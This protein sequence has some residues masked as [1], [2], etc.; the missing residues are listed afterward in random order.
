M[1]SLIQIVSLVVVLATQIVYAMGVDFP[2]PN[3]GPAVAS[4]ND[5]V[6]TLENNVITATWDA[7][8]AGLRPASI[9]NK[10]TGQRFDQ[11]GSEL[12]RVSTK[13]TVPSDGIYGVAIRLGPDRITVF[14]SQDDRSP[15]EIASFPRT[16]FPGDPATIRVG[17]MNLKAQA[18]D[19]GGD[20]GA[21]GEG[22]IFSIRPAP[23]A[24]AADHFEFKTLA[25]KTATSSFPFPA[26]TKRVS[27]RIDKGT[28]TGL[29]WAPALALV[30]EEGT[31]F[32]LVGVR[33]NRGVFNVTTATGERGASPK[34]GEFPV[35]D[36]PA[37]AFK[38]LAPATISP[39]LLALNT[40]RIAESIPGKAI[41]AAFISPEGLRATW[42]AELRDGSNYIRQTVDFTAPEK[43]VSL[44]GVELIDTQL[45]SAQPIG[46]VPGCPVAGSGLFL[47]VEIPGSRTVVTD[48]HARIGFA[49]KLDVSPQ[50][51]YR[52]GAVTGIAP[53]GQLR[54]AFLYYIERERARASQPFLH[55]NC[56]YDLGYGLTED[57]I[58]DVVQQFDAELV[59]KRGVPVQSYL[60]DDG[61]DDPSKGL[62]LEH[63]KRFPTGFGGL[64]EKLDRYGAHLGIW[65][66][67][68]GGYGGDKERTALGRKMGL[69]PEDSIFDLS[70]PKYRQWFEDR[71]LQLMRECGVNAFKWDRAGNGVTPHFM[72]LLHVAQK[73]RLQN[74]DVFINVTAGTW[75]SPFWLNHV[76]STWRNNS[77]DVGW[78]GKG[79]DREK[80][81]TFRDGYCRKLFAIASPLYPLN[82]VMH[83]GL[84]HGRAFQGDKVGKSG[85]HLTNEA[86]SYFATGASL[87]ELYITPSMMT[88]EAWDAVAESAKWAHARADVLADSHWVGGD[89]LTLQ[90]YGYASWNARQGTLMLRNPDDQK[91]TMTIDATT[92]FELPATAPKNYTLTSPYADQRV[93]SITLSA[94]TPYEIN[95]E[96]F[97]VLVF[98]AIPDQH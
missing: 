60:A 51:S 28:D 17:K 40:R 64:K 96:P 68:L 41:E 86:R 2:G 87:Q 19:H 82:S 58:V 32:I 52:F 92:V 66:S 83:H 35:G 91:K 9:T 71:C 38:L 65:I 8:N 31:R 73:L 95:L 77:N 76:D 85:P 1:K 42:R 6:M 18:R 67:P 98:D 97:E 10:L 89:P 48:E 70:H 62:W 59:K 22:R 5:G 90:P 16:D 36:L 54:R 34:F 45:E 72:A 11:S 49:C 29:S 23:V 78:A 4:Q 13:Q 43:S 94:G 56:W 63:A 12:F 57:K 74:P 37:S 15:V 46:T 53:E 84:V 80:W 44:Y 25:H 39:A 33:D 21:I 79:D 26:G 50:Q 61:W 14:A 47:G 93:R 75:P 30:W 24:P 69:I 20:M 81:L 3:P 27:A 7:R 55:Y 88:S